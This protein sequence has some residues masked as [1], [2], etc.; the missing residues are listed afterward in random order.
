MFL[1]LMILLQ[2][3]ITWQKQ[4]TD[5]VVYPLFTVLDRAYSI[6]SDYYSPNTIFVSHTVFT[7]I[8]IRASMD[9]IQSVV[10][11]NYLWPA[12]SG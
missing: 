11:A 10:A 1:C 5:N 8:S 12:L 2:L 6:D 7:K 9:A 3:L 4:T